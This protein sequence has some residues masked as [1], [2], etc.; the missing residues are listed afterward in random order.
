MRAFLD[1]A[2]SDVDPDLKPIEQCDD[3]EIDLQSWRFQP[4]REGVQSIHT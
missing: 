4:C 2:C 3:A 1:H